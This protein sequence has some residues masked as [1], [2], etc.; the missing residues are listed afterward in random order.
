MSNFEKIDFLVLPVIVL[1]LK[2]I[3]PSTPE[4]LLKIE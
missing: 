2:K 4:L 3:T 1:D